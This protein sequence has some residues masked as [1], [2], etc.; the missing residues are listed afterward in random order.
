VTLKNLKFQQEELSD[1]ITWINSPPPKPICEVDEKW[2]GVMP[3][4]HNSF[5][6]VF[7]LPVFLGLCLTLYWFVDDVYEDWKYREKATLEFIK[8][9]KEKEGDDYFE[10]LREYTEREVSIQVVKQSNSFSS[11]KAGLEMYDWIKNGKMSFKTHMHYRYHGTAYPDRIRRADTAMVIFH[12]IAIPTLLISI[13]RIRRRAPIYFDRE[14]NLVYTWRKGEVWAQ[15]YDNLT[16]ND[17]HGLNLGLYNRDLRPKSVL[18]TPSFNSEFEYQLPLA[19][20]TKFM[21]HGREAIAR[22]NW[23]DRQGF[24]LLNDKKPEDFEEQLTALMK[25]IRDV[26]SY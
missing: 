24:Y 11:A 4:T 26:D 10:N 7:L 8:Y 17:Q 13:I 2:L 25:K 9:A 16:Y 21:V 3:T 18:V 19:F 6:N 15:D 22:K 1:V 14:Q 12:S 20:I 23:K 5:R